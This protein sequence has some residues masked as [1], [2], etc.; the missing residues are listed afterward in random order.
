MQ[1]EQQTGSCCV[2]PGEIS[3][4]TLSFF[5]PSYLPL[6]VLKAPPWVLP[7]VYLE[8]GACPHCTACLNG[9]SQHVATPPPPPPPTLTIC[10]SPLHGMRPTHSNTLG[11][12]WSAQMCD[13]NIPMP[14]HICWHSQLKP[15]SLSELW[16]FCFYQH[17][18]VVDDSD[19]YIN[20]I[21][22]F[23]F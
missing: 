4:L 18:L 19:I 21:Q 22:R 17:V 11:S 14:V 8:L 15:L 10:P 2:F 1:P 20:V 5:S 3:P 13:Q 9:D 12:T 16:R 6:P 7:Q 23:F